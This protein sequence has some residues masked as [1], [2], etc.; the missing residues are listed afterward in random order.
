MLM[1]IRIYLNTYIYIYLNCYMENM[2]YNI[3]H[4]GN[5]FTMSVTLWDDPSNDAPG[6]S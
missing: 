4:C 2:D 6:Q 5:T 1:Y 3:L